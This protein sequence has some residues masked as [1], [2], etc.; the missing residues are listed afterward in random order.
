MT[1]SE[2]FVNA[3]RATGQG[4]SFRLPKIIT[5]RDSR[6]RV[7][8]H[9]LRLFLFTFFFFFVP[10]IILCFPFPRLLLNFFFLL[11]ILPWSFRI[12]GPA[13]CCCSSYNNNY[14][15]GWRQ[16]WLTE[17]RPWHCCARVVH[18]SKNN[19]NNNNPVS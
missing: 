14:P 12:P 1:R 18:F 7:L 4:R 17:W 8:L 6:S 13:D 16:A 15:V 3:A 2:N 11:L 19:D 10:I 9:D 5:S